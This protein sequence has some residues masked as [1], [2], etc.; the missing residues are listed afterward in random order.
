M[1]GVDDNVA[2]PAVSAGV[3][4]ARGVVPLTTVAAAAGVVP[5][6]RVVENAAGDDS[7]AG[8]GKD[9]KDDDATDTGTAEESATAP[10]AP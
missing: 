5:S 7:T 1:A 6:W 4:D 3:V 8:A 2:A 10:A 9:I